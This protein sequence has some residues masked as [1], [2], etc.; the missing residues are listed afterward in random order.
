MKCYFACNDGVG[1]RPEYRDML[2]VSLKTARRN[3]TLDL[4]CIYSGSPKD[5]AVSLME[6]YGVR[7]IFHTISFEDE[8][9]EL[10]TPEFMLQRLGRV[11]ARDGVLGTFTRMDLPLIEAEDEFVLF[12]DIDV[13]FLRDIREEDLPRP[14]FC[15]AGPEIRQDFDVAMRGHRFFNAGVMYLNVPGMREKYVQFRSMLRRK[16]LSKIEC[17]DQGYLNHICEKDFDELPLEYNWKPYWGVS[18]EA[19]IVHFHSVKPGGNFTPCTF[20][21]FVLSTFDD[22]VVGLLYY[23]IMFYNYLGRSSISWLLGYSRFLM[24]EKEKGR[25]SRQRNIEKR[26]K[27]NARTLTQILIVAGVLCILWAVY[28]RL[29]C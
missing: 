27:R 1:K 8:L 16:E 17:F 4:Y 18:Q 19:K 28:S 10:Y 21:D 23:Q 9:M 26:A 13:M 7:V 3:T 25:I 2:E 12:C 5:E 15:A 20:Y 6:H 24:H 22:A 11:E 29:L 14:L